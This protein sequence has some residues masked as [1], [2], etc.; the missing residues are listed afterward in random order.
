MN[1][2]SPNGS[3]FRKWNE[4]RPMLVRKY[5]TRRTNSRQADEVRLAQLFGINVLAA[6][7]NR[8]TALPGHK[9]AVAQDLHTL[10]TGVRVPVRKRGSNR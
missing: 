5:S 3:L 4:F 2:E 8:S 6:S 7:R 9:P 1:R 10:L